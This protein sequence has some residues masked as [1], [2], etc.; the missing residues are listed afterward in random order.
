MLVE[1]NQQRAE[2]DN[3]CVSCCF[4]PTLLQVSFTGCKKY[5]GVW[6]TGDFP[7]HGNVSNILF[8]LCI[9]KVLKQITSMSFILFPC[10]DLSFS[11]SLFSSQSSS[12]GILP[13]LQI[14]KN[15]LKLWLF[16]FIN[17]KK[18]FWIKCK[19]NK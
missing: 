9:Y 15:A 17:M 18:W 4:W 11:F 6:I 8:P 2:L 10:W 12:P 14:R 5:L 1:V 7:L 3:C 16:L 13:G 19:R